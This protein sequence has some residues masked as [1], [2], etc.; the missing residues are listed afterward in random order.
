MLGRWGR[1]RAF[2]DSSLAFARRARFDAQ[3]KTPRN[4]GRCGAL[5]VK[6]AAYLRTGMGWA[7]S[8][9]T[10]VTLFCGEPSISFSE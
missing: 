8:T 3:I 4:D 10:A 6:P 2:K 7:L 1:C 9:G 5:V